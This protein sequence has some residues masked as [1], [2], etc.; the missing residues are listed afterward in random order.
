MT[1]R[2]YILFITICTICTIQA[3]AIR[4]GAEQTEKLIPLLKGKRIAL[5]VNQTSI[6]GETQ[7]HLE[8]TRPIHQPT[9]VLHTDEF[10]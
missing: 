4:T 7:T 1:R 3:Q 10:L 2:F 9:D 5:V 6:V 8:A